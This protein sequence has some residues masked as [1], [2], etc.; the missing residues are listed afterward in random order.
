MRLSLNGLHLEANHGASEV[1]RESSRP[2]LLDIEL[3]LPDDCGSLDNLSNTVDYA[4]VASLAI[5]VC[6]SPARNLIETVAKST[7]R[8]ILD[9]FE[10]VESVTIRLSKLNPPM[11]A[12]CDAATVEYTL[13]R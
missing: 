12:Q 7:A 5:T 11:D 3:E 10:P 13:K 4:Q 9:Q 6:S 2:F 8:A 1:E